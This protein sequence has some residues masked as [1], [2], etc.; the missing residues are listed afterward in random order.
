MNCLRDPCPSSFVFTTVSKLYP[1]STSGELVPLRFTMVTDCA[2]VELVDKV[3]MFAPVVFAPASIRL[4][5]F[6]PT[7]FNTSDIP[8]VLKV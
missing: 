8:S 6:P 1:K 3:D 4:G 7:S 2:S 5:E